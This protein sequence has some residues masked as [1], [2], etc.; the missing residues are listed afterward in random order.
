MIRSIL[1]PLLTLSVAVASFAFA[2]EEAA[3]F[4]RDGAFEFSQGNCELAQYF[5]QEALKLEPENVEAMVGK[6][7]AL[8]CRNAFDL[9]IAEF[10][11]A[12]ERDPGNIEAYVEMA[13]A[14]ESQALT[15]PDRYPN[16]LNDALAAL[17]RA[18]ERAPDNAEVLNTK[19]VILY[20]LNDLEGARAALEAA[21]DRARRPDGGLSDRE[22]SVVQVN[23]GKVHRDLGDMQQALRAFRTAVVLDP[24]NASA[25]NNLGNVYFRM[26][27]CDQ[28][29][30]ELSQAVALAPESLSAMSQLGIALFECGR[31]EQSVPHLERAIDLDGSV[32]LPPLFTYLGR[33]YSQIG[34][35]DEAIKR[36]QQ[37]ALLGEESPAPANAEGYYWLGQVYERRGAS[38]DAAKAQ[39]AYRR[40][41][42]LD[43]SFTPAQEA[44]AR[45]AG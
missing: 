5:Y 29:E 30:F 8:A 17:E 11:K 22:R 25:H 16:R 2:Q 12:I 14:F 21:V 7:K 26:A 34:R 39:A 44:L 33:A 1:F 23:L 28:A 41:L 42:E 15:D 36:A 38:G 24:S 10:Q 32:F 31:V 6:G 40:A 43:E 20:R 3:E 18:E 35:H 45:L 13:R 4:I 37:G 27:E 9:A 19:G